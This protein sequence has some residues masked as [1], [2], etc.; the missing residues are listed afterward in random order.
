MPARRAI[1]DSDLNIDGCRQYERARLGGV[2]IHHRAGPY[3]LGKP[4]RQ[5]T[6]VARR[7]YSGLSLKRIHRV[8]N[9]AIGATGGGSTGVGGSVAVSVL[10]EDT[11]AY[12]ADNAVVTGADTVQNPGVSVEA[13]D[14]TI[15]TS[16]AGAVAG[17]GSAGVGAGFDIGV[18][19]KST[20][21]YIGDATVSTDGDRKIVADSDERSCPSPR[22]RAGNGPEVAHA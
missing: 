17:G 11:V 7:V 4:H 22:Q 21:A 8:A 6:Q 2:G 9:A 15:I 12:I 18:I 1:C 20:E 5:R 19:I 14:A 3:R 13:S 16:V 10:Y